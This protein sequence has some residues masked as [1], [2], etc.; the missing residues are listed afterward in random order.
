MVS[1]TTSKTLKKNTVNNYQ[2]ILSK[3][4]NQYGD[5]VLESIT[6]DEVLTFLTQ[7]NRNTKQ[8]TKR[9]RY[10]L[11]NAFFNLIKNTIDDT[12]QNP[13]D[14]MML[15]KVFRN[16]RGVQWKIF[17]KEIIDEIIFKTENIRN[18]LLLELMARGGMRIGE[19]LKIRPID[20]QDRKITLPEPKSGKEF[21]VVFIPQKVADR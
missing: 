1:I 10:S 4:S 2:A 11:L 3:F 8:T 19:V 7:I 14:T 21:E 13:C 5:R 16:I 6:S 15:R 12:I 20:I 9:L 18:R 17:E